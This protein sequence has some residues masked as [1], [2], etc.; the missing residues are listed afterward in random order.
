[1]TR[2]V[3]SLALVG[4]MCL[5]GCKLLLDT[6]AEKPII[7]APPLKVTQKASPVSPDEISP[8]NAHGKA[9]QLLE[10]LESEGK[11]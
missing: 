3:L 8:A 9:R 7:Q 11:E 4:V 5:S 1:M 10:E 2:F 6:T